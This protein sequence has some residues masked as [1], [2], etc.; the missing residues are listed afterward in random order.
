MSI[1]ACFT[2]H[3]LQGQQEKLV[4]DTVKLL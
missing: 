2:G 1:V 4:I 3:A